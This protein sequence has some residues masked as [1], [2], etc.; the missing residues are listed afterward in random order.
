MK[1]LPKSLL[2]AA[3]LS[4]LTLFT[5][6][7][8]IVEKVEFDTMN[9]G[10]FTLVQD[11]TEMYKLMG[12]MGEGEGP[13]AEEKQEE[14]QKLEEELKPLL[15][16]LEKIEGISNPTTGHETENFSAFVQFDFASIDALNHGMSVIYSTQLEMEEIPKNTYFKTGRRKI[17]RTETRDMI[18]F[19]REDMQDDS[20]EAAQFFQTASFE[21]QYSFPK[22]I[23]KVT[24]KD[25]SY[26]KKST[27][28]TYSYFLFQEDFKEKPI[29]TTIRF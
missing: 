13:T 26:E 23:K 28:L 3:S 21:L 10:T 17:V 22:K 6:C 20:A 29:G 12:S 2:I 16:L 27:S 19:L 14:L 4:L 7:F 18:D 1:T 11:L 8:R 5:G 24:N 25:I 15:P 9:S